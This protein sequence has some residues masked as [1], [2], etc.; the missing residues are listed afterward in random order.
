M[1][2]NSQESA[3]AAPPLL[4]RVTIQFCTQ[5]KWLL[6]AAYY[7][8]ELLSTFNTS[9]GEVALQP[10]TG[11]VF[12]VEITH[13]P[14]PPTAP[15]TGPDSDSPTATLNPKPAVRRTVLWDR[16]ADGGFP[17]TKE[18]KRRVRDVIEPGRN[19]GHVD[20]DYH[21]KT[22]TTTT[23]TSSSQP[24]PSSSSGDGSAGGN[25]PQE[26]PKE[27][28]FGEEAAAH[29]KLTTTG[30]ADEGVNYYSSP[31]EILSRFRGGLGAP[32]PPKGQG[33]DWTNAPSTTHTLPGGNGGVAGVKPM[34]RK[35]PAEAQERVQARMDASSRQQRQ[36]QQTP[37]SGVVG[38]GVEKGDNGDS[39][40]VTG[41]AAAAAAAAACGMDG[42]CE[43]CE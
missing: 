35:P 15:P 20:R 3:T 4:P 5:C 36:Q 40:R 1:A 27:G 19:L 24:T 26:A 21:S 31:D 11:G 14:A 22:T 38:E 2:D 39:K 23:T 10:S 33:G 17:E 16:K 25:E 42:V 32:P 9:L 29:S 7:A 43:D 34:M 18:L 30:N 8:Q 41:A 6:R 13:S 12:I 37:S 28:P